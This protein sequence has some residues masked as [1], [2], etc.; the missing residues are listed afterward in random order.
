MHAA[1]ES[2]FKIDTVYFQER[3]KKIIEFAFLI[4]IYMDSN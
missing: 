4:D 1:S 3:E 2:S